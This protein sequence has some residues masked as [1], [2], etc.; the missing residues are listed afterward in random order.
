MKRIRK[1]GLIVVACL[2]AIGV[3]QAAPVIDKPAVLPEAMLSVTVSDL[4]GLIDGIGSVAAQVSPMMNGMMLKSMIGAQ[5]G[6]PGLMGIAPGNG[7]AVV[8]LDPTNIFAVVELAEVQ[9][10]S[11]YTNVLVP[12]QLEAKYDDGL[13]IVAQTKAQ[14]AMGVE[15]A[16]AVKSTLLAKRSPTLRI[17]L[18][19]AAIIERN[20]DS[21]QGMLAMMPVLMGQNMMQTPGTTVESAELTTQILEGEVRVLLSLADQ[22]DSAEVVLAPKN[23]SIRITETFVPKAGSRLETLCNA[24]AINPP[25][26]KIESGYFEGGMILFDSLI[27]NP[28]ALM[29]FVVAETELLFKEMEISDV[30]LSGWNSFCEK[31]WALLG[32]SLCESVGFDTESGMS[33]GYLMDV[34]DEAGALDLL[35]TLSQDMEPFTKLYDDLGMPMTVEFREGVREYKGIKIHQLAI[36]MA[37]TNQS[38]EVAAQLSEMNLTNMVYD[39]AITDGVMI[40]AMGGEKVE[41]LLDRL[42]DEAFTPAPL[43]ARSVYPADGFYYLDL[44]MGKYMTSVAS[45]MPAPWMEQVMPLLQGV[46]PITS[47]GFKAEGR[48]MWSINIP[49]DLLTKIGQVVM[50]IQMQQMQQGGGMPQGALMQ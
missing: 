40:Y 22:C 32:G 10:A 41:P 16:T 48:V 42:G 21:I 45:I 31:W 13:M 46:E 1:S 19:P 49:G 43:K 30:D 25:N 2:G 37:M 14:V 20:D 24:P 15:L 50:M 11:F 17:A 27:A 23:G 6:D 36:Q 4:H 34:N 5:L 28:E 3:L 18:Q 38:E 29:A 33:V 8:A 9:A 44:D 35:K 12:K 26:P 7:F 39:I 47:A